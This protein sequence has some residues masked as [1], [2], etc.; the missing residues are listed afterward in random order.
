VRIG[1]HAGDARRLGANYHGRGVHA[2]ARIGALGGAGE[3]VASA[4][5]LDGRRD[6]RAGDA[7]TVEL[8]GLSEPVEVVTVDWR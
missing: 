7:R 6:V 3:I 4:A 2:A 1:L 5:T 8:K